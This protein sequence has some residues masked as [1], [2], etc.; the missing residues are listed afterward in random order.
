VSLAARPVRVT[1]KSGAA[2]ALAS[3]VE[4]LPRGRHIFLVIGGLRADRQ[5]GVSFDVYLDLPPDAPPAQRARHLAGNIHYY[6]AVIGETGNPE[7]IFSFDITDLARTLASRGLL[8][9]ET[10]LVIAPADGPPAGK[11]VVGRIEIVE[12]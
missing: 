7:A 1:L 9:G 10:T 12:Q 3:R 2:K 5:P 8:R 11:P 6:D 4:A